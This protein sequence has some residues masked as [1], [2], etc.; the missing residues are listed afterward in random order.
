MQIATTT[1]LIRIGIALLC[2]AVLGLE[3]ERLERAAGLR[4][5]A[6]VAVSSS[7][8]MI[9]STYGFA[10]VMGVSR[11]SFDPSRVAAQVVS[12]IG[13][14]GAGVIIFRKNTVSGLT[15]A[16]SVWS[17]AAVGL[18]CGGGLFW[19]ALIVTAAIIAIQIVLRF[20]ERRF[21]AH[22]NPST[23][24]VRMKHAPGQIAAVE[25]I[26]L[27]SGVPL[28]GLRLRTGRSEDR[29]ELVMGNA[30]ETAVLRLVN[31]LGALEG[32]GSVLYRTMNGRLRSSD[33]RGLVEEALGTAEDEQQSVA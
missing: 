1:V 31:R 20:I 23:L 26:V 18:A 22:H 15:T 10:D 25:R 3:R 8:L 7:L 13:F 27:D 17:A 5:H 11:V 12:G 4:T 24:S 14:L 21:F 16:A 2:G 33:E 32:V 6:L 29:I 9:V 30:R 28:R 19:A